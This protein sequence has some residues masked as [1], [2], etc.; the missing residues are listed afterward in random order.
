MAYPETLKDLP[1]KW[2]KASICF[3]YARHR[4]AEG[5][6]SVIP[7]IKGH[8]QCLYLENFENYIKFCTL[9]AGLYNFLQRRCI[10]LTRIFS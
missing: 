3:S 7:Y 10:Q 8:G 9:L 2:N 4:P 1:S 5:F 6:Y